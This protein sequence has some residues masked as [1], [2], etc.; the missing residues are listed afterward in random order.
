[1]QDRAFNVKERLS[2]TA[3]LTVQVTVNKSNPI[4]LGVFYIKSN[5]SISQDVNDQ[6]PVFIYPNCPL[7]QLRVCETTPTYTAEV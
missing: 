7:N 6:D 1:M 4:A 5:R 3:T 2:S